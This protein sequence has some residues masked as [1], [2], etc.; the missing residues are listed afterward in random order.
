M[1]GDN[2]ES[3]LA[4]AFTIR[5]LI[6]FE[7]YSLY[8]KYLVRKLLLS[9]S[10][11]FFIDFQDHYVQRIV[12]D[13]RDVILTKNHLFDR[14]FIYARATHSLILHLIDE[15][16]PISLGARH[17]VELFSFERFEVLTYESRANFIPPHHFSV[18]YE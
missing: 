16:Q 9:H 6:Y 18:Y 3:L 12:R 5:L 17:N 11:F 15:S 13:I 4:F 1:R 14:G 10:Y 2:C 7:N 8:A